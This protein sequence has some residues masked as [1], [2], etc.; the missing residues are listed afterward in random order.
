MGSRFRPSL[1]PVPER[2][3]C[4]A[5]AAPSSFVHPV[6]NRIFGASGHMNAT[7]FVHGYRDTTHPQK[8]RQKENQWEKR[9][10]GLR[11]KSE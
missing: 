7:S 2:G 9:D 4:T 3:G 8:P 6:L 1:Q 5:D 11:V 10:S